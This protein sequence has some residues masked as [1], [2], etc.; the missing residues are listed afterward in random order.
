MKRYFLVHKPFMVLCQFTSEGD[1]KNLS[2]LGLPE[3]IYPAGRLDK[4]SEGLILLT[5]DG[6]L[7]NQLLEPKKE[8]PRTYH[9]QVDNIPNS[10]AIEKMKSGLLIKNYQ[11]KPCSV[12]LLRERP[13][14]AERTPPIRIRKNIP[15]SWL[16]VILT[17]G[18]NRQLR[19]MTAAIN[20]PTLRLIRTKI[21]NLTLDMVPRPGDILE[22]KR[23]D[24]KL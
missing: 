17:E 10:D 5:D 7:I 6:P 13:D 19:R 9:V 12:N 8:H 23:S 14:H 22:I 20:H 24:I 16:E 1:V 18:K 21:L 2:E 4:D 15:T 11:T 3:G